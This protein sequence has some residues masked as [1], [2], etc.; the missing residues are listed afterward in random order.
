MQ[1]ELR[2]MVYNSLPIELDGSIN[3]LRKALAVKG[4]F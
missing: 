3:L 4:K 2:E 1:K